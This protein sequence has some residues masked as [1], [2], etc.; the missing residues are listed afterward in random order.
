MHET[1]LALI[2]GTHKLVYYQGYENY[3][4]QYELYNLENDPDELVDIY[5]SD[6]RSGEMQEILDQ[7]SKEIHQTNS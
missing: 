5:T 1:T 4:D 3:K 7:K 2:K 6:P